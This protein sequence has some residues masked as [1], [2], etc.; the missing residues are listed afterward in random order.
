M[1]AKSE[2]Q[3]IVEINTELDTLLAKFKDN[4][5]TIV[6]LITTMDAVLDT[7]AAAAGTGTTT[8]LTADMVILL[9]EID[10]ILDT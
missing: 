4:D 6:S 10:D 8:D 1:T 7:A 3:L 2:S 9:A 5:A